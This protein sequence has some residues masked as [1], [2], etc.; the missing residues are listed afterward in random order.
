MLAAA[1]DADQSMD[2]ALE[3]NGRAVTQV[4]YRDG[5]SLQGQ[6]TPALRGVHA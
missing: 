3:H 1:I 6:E 5:V 4:A 2:C